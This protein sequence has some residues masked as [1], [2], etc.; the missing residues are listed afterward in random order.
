MANKPKLKE[1]ATIFFGGYKEK[2]QN[3]RMEVKKKKG[4]MS[5]K[6]F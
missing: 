5:S 4:K 3:W 1:L 6:C 2:S